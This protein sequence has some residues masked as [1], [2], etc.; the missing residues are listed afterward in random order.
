MLCWAFLI[1]LG[2][3]F[4]ALEKKASRP[5]WYSCLP[6]TIRTWAELWNSL[7]VRLNPLKLSY[8][9]WL[10][11]LHSAH[12]FE[13]SI[14]IEDSRSLRSHRRRAL[15]LWHEL[16]GLFGFIHI[17]SWETKAWEESNHRLSANQSE[18]KK[19]KWC[20]MKNVCY[21]RFANISYNI[22][23]ISLI[24][25]WYWYCYCCIYNVEA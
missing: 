25:Y 5:Q 13:E 15:Y 12:K 20:K 19:K 8:A 9:I 10:D 24:F 7:L 11:P 22:Q 1:C 4:L 21:I 2:C 3:C 23:L 14:D 6:L 18:G 17:Y 16:P